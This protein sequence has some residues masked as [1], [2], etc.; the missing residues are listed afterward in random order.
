[1]LGVS[2]KSKVISMSVGR[3]IHRHTHVFTY[4]SRYVKI[5]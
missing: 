1:M 5:V 3:N 2:K 4:T